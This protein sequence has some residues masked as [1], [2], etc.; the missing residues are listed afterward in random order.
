[1]WLPSVYT[2]LHTSWGTLHPTIHP[3]I[4]ASPIHLLLAN[5]STAAMLIAP[6]HLLD[7]GAASYQDIYP[8]PAAALTADTISS[9]MACMHVT[10]LQ[11]YHC[12]IL[13]NRTMP[14]LQHCGPL[15]GLQAGIGYRM[16]AMHGPALMTADKEGCSPSGQSQP[17]PCRHQSPS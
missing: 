9:P 16:G 13:H 4:R 15:R 1:M 8:E 10:I 2:R 17:A 3:V 5:P 12:G 6:Q 14:T 11:L 7:I